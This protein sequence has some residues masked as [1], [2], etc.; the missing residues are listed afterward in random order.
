M[1]TPLIN[2]IE[3][4]KYEEAKV[5]IDSFPLEIS[6]FIKLVSQRRPNGSTCFHHCAVNQNS[7]DVLLSIYKNFEPIRSKTDDV[8][9]DLLCL[10]TNDGRSASR[11]AVDNHTHCIYWLI[12]DIFIKYGYNNRL[13]EL[14]QSDIPIKRY[15]WNYTFSN[16]YVP[17]NEHTPEPIDNYIKMSKYIAYGIVIYYGCKWIYNRFSD[18]PIYILVRLRD[19]RMDD[20]AVV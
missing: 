18:S 16:M 5:M 11:V 20:L 15:I 3:S 19:F 4:G 6:E 2:L 1:A 7:Y 10:K 14:H 9:I 8:L 17:M 12:N 13:I